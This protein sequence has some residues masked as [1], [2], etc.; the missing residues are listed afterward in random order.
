M[1]E[2]LRKSIK[3]KKELVLELYL[4]NKQLDLSSGLL[5]SATQFCSLFEIFLHDYNE[6]SVLVAVDIDGRKTPRDAF[7]IRRAGGA[8][9]DQ[10]LRT[11]IYR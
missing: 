8:A 10:A 1:P 5:N 11:A 2:T 9:L 7:R 3:M 4:T 6:Y